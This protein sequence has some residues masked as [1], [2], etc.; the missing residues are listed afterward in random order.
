MHRFLQMFALLADVHILIVDP[1]PAV[2]N[3]VVI[4]RFD[5]LNN[6]R[7]TRQRHRHAK[8]RQRQTAFLKFIVDPPEPGAAAVFVEGV[9]GHMFVGVAGCTDDVRQELL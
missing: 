2:A 9:H 3:H 4:R 8:D 1:A 7:V 6:I 5:R